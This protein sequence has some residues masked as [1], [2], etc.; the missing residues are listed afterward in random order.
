M[1]RKRLVRDPIFRRAAGISFGVD[2]STLVS[3]QEI[4][5]DRQCAGDHDFPLRLYDGRQRNVLHARFSP[6]RIGDAQGMR[7][8]A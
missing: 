4:E 3:K 2:V 1:S 6:A 7:V 8:R 5:S